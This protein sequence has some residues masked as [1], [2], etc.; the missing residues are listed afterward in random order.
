MLKFWGLILSLNL[1]QPTLA[2][3]CSGGT[4]SSF[5][6]ELSKVVDELDERVIKIEGELRVA[7]DRLS[8]LQSAQGRF[9]KGKEKNDS[10]ELDAFKRAEAAATELRTVIDKSLDRNNSKIPNDSPHDF[11]KKIRDL[12]QSGIEKIEHGNLLTFSEPDLD[13]IRIEISHLLGIKQLAHLTQEYLQSIK[14]QISIRFSKYCDEEVRGLRV[15]VDGQALHLKDCT[16]TPNIKEIEAEAWGG[17]LE[18]DLCRHIMMCS[19]VEGGQQTQ[20]LAGFWVIE[21]RRIKEGC[22]SVQECAH[23][24]FNGRSS[25]PAKAGL[26]PISRPGGG[27]Q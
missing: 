11:A 16:P 14:Q 25:S 15:E 3:E 20:N 12:Y 22:P 21:C 19:R 24:T 1:T 13:K 4:E 23:Q 10:I 18:K 5:R 9:P 7:R 6:A 26:A 2:N 27:T 17:K 8:Q